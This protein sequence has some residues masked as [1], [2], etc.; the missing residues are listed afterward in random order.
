MEPGKKTQMRRL[1]PV[2]VSV[3]FGK[4][5]APWLFGWI[6]WGKSDLGNTVPGVSMAHRKHSEE[7]LSKDKQP[8]HLYQEK[9][10]ASRVFRLPQRPRGSVI[11]SEC[12]RVLCVCFLSLLLPATVP[13][14]ISPTLSPS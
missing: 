11:L 7:L 9:Y 1:G 8:W 6:S 10:L 5:R 2:S 14:S 4:G 13:P 3:R 12:T